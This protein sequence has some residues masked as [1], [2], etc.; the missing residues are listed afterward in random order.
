[1]GQISGE[2][3]R[4]CFVHLYVYEILAFLLKKSSDETLS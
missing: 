2:I 4:G 1:M 3:Q